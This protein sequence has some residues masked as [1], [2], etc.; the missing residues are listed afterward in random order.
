M[1]VW[2][3]GIFAEAGLDRSRPAPRQL[4]GAVF[5]SESPNFPLV[6]QCYVSL[7]LVAMFSCGIHWGS[8]T[9]KR[10]PLFSVLLPLSPRWLSF[11]APVLSLHWW[12]FSQPTPL[13]SLTDSIVIQ[14]QGRRLRL[15]L[16]LPDQD[17]SDCAREKHSNK[18]LLDCNW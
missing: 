9:V 3:V 7:V 4:C 8:F 10:V 13:H 14:F 18:V 16:P 17:T 2:S 6:M 5:W 15:R 1:V 12:L 11:R